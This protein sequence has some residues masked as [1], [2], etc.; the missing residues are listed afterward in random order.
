MTAWKIEEHG[1]TMPE[2]TSSR[3]RLLVGQTNEGM[4]PF[5]LMAQRKTYRTR[6]PQVAYLS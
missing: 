5:I 1:C 3:S 4:M 2:N 6:L